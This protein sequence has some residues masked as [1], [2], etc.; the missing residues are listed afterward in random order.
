MG[1]SGG[2][3][4]SPAAVTQ[5]EGGALPLCQRPAGVWAGDTQRLGGSRSPGERP[6]LGPE[7]SA[8]SAGPGRIYW[9]EGHLPND[10]GLSTLVPLVAG[11]FVAEPRPALGLLLEQMGHREDGVPL[12]MVP[13]S[14][15][16]VPGGTAC[17]GS[18]GTGWE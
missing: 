1:Q 13:F 3:V 12:Q 15:P 7:F 6:F 10:S 2:E 5:T 17:D 14:T 16:A 4:P 11:T 18:C 8:S 9:V